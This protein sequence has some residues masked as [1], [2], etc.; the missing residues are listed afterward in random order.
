MGLVWGMIDWVL[1]RDEGYSSKEGPGET[2]SRCGQ[3]WSPDSGAAAATTAV[4]SAVAPPPS[5]KQYIVAKSM[6]DSKISVKLCMKSG[7]AEIPMWVESIF[8]FH[9]SCHSFS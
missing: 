8:C 6:S 5:A 9:G 3:S 7:I 4:M 2:S 1:S